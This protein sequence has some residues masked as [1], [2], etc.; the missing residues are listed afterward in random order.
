VPRETGALG[1][2]VDEECALGAETALGAE[3]ALAAVTWV[4]AVD[5]LSG[6]CRTLAGV[7]PA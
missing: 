2:A 6:T 7:T 1:V 3:I 5:P 4:D